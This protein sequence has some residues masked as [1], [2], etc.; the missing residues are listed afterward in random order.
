MRTQNNSTMKIYILVINDIER[1]GYSCKGVEIFKTIEEA[2]ERMKELYLERCE[3]W[4]I[5]DPLADGNFDY[6]L[7]SDYAYIFG[8]YYLDIFEKEV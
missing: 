2:K 8:E 4:D 6:N 1:V 5:K 3:E 7:G